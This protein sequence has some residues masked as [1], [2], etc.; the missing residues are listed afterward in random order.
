MVKEA[1]YMSLYQKYRPR[2]LEH[3]KGQP[4]IVK[5]LQNAVVNNR[6]SHAYLFT[7][8]Y[9]GGKT[10]LSR[11]LA[12]MLNCQR[13]M[14]ATPCGVCRICQRIMTGNS[15]D[16]VEMDAASNRGIDNIR[17][18]TESSSVAPVES[19]RKIYILDECH[20]LTNDAANALLKTLEEP[21]PNLHFCLCTTEPKK[22]LDTIKSR[23]QHFEVRSIS[24]Q[25]IAEQLVLIAKYENINIESSSLLSIAHLSNG[26]MRDAVSNL[27]GIW[28][29]CGNND[30]KEVDIAV[31][32]GKP[33]HTVAYDL[34][35]AIISTDIN[36]ALG[37]IS[38]QIASGVSADALL[39]DLS[40]Y[41]RNLMLV[42]ATNK[43]EILNLGKDMS[44]K[45]IGHVQRLS[46]VAKSVMI[47][48]ALEEAQRGI[49]FSIQ[50][51]H[52]LEACVVKAMIILSSG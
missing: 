36:K 19:K 24:P 30:I 6:V 21:S 41:W 40:T 20:A 33:A 47:F 10:T 26:S 3:V 13:G 52:V 12:C 51:L 2:C 48:Q 38:N 1:K 8:Q 49:A 25:D 29:Y 45:I 37:I 34:T 23:C 16:V 42:K 28:N 27:E 35:D 31:F 5:S 44:M 22:V 11:I 18:L 46:N 15:I 9:G 4:H 7:G 39:L 43:V 14:S 17:A 50:S 32:F